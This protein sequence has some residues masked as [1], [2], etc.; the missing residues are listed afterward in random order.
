MIGPRRLRI[1]EGCVVV[2]RPHVLEELIQ[3]VKAEAPRR[4]TSP[5]PLSRCQ[6]CREFGVAHGI[7][8]ETNETNE[9][10]RMNAAIVEGRRRP[11]QVAA[12]LERKAGKPV[13]SGGHHQAERDVPEL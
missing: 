3:P 10:T 7:V 6:K 5:C 13:L 11:V 2:V 8:T 12:L 1:L 9:P 4:L